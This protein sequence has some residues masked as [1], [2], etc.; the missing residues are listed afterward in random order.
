M[1][2][3]RIEVVLEL[4]SCSP[5]SGILTDRSVSYRPAEF[6]TNEDIRLNPDSIAQVYIFPSSVI[7]A[8]LILTTFLPGVLVPD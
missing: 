3:V 7:Q 2:V 5:L 8:F 1:T 4:S 6:K